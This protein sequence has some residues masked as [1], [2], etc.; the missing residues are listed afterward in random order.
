M[1]G[2]IL[3]MKKTT[4]LKLSF[5]L[6]GLLFVGLST[7][8]FIQN[9]LNNDYF[10]FFCLCAGAH[11]GLKSALF[12]LDS[13]CFLGSVLFFVGGFYF[14]CLFFDILFIFP[15][16]VLLAFCVAFFITHCFFGRKNQFF[17]AFILLF[18]AIFTFL[19]QIKSI[20]LA[21]FLALMGIIVLLLV[22][23]FLTIK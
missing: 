7:L 10:F 17:L 2:R 15:S 14:Y 12:R 23:R 6:S 5:I 4:I 21:F 22:V 18:V 16:F 11:L 8:S 9:G 3:G 20:S 19:F 1:R 13:S